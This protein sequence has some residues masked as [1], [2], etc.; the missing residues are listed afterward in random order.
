M[1]P[2]SHAWDRKI[3]QQCLLVLLS[4]YKYSSVLMMS[5]LSDHVLSLKQRSY[6]DDYSTLLFVEHL[7]RMLFFRL[8]TIQYICL[9][10]HSLTK[11]LRMSQSI[12]DFACRMSVHAL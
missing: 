3:I 9:S 5:M 7:S 12:I 10:H 6:L 2:T 4:C 8:V 1:D 11:V